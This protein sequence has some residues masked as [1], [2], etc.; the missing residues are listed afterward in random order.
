M[1]KVNSRCYA[2]AGLLGNPSDGYHG[3]AISFAF[4]NCYAEMDLCEFVTLEFDEANQFE[5]LAHF[6]D[7]VKFD[8]QDGGT[9]LLKAALFRWLRHFPE[10]LETD[11]PLFQ[12]SFNSN[13]PRQVGL[14]GSSAIVIA[15]LRAFSQWYGIEVRSELLASI[16]LAAEIDLGISAGL[17]DRVAQSMQGLVYM[18]FD[19]SKM[20]HENNLAV[21]EYVHLDWS[22]AEHFYI[23]YARNIPESTQVLH[24]D[25]RKRF[26][27][28]EQK[29]VDTIQEIAE[30]A[31]QGRNALAVGDYARLSELIDRN[32]DLRQS[33]CVLN[34]GHVRMIE[35][36]REC[37]VSA[38]Y[39]GSGGAIVGVCTDKSTFCLLYTSPSPRD[40]QKSRMPSSA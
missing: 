15:A 17:Q 38:K 35:V 1:K 19:A 18:D 32:F 5:S 34:P 11:Q 20:H 12:L 21:G 22:F 14:A 7:D 26:E 4:Q 2:R 13:I 9:R 25:L 27:A 8:E 30:L 23:A 6:V 36:A 24:G 31:V 39:C 3:K 33:I 28:K 10:C 16:A 40:R 29:V 37:G